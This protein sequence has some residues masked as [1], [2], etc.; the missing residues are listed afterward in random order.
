[1]VKI[2]KIKW[3]QNNDIKKH[4][5]CCIVKNCKW[6]RNEMQLKLYRDETIVN[7][8]KTTIIYGQ[9]NKKQ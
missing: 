6:G 8:D 7:E 1:M 4:E 9:V 2:D 3:R 5:G